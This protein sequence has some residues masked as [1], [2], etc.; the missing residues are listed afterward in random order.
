[1]KCPKC[2]K[3]L[4]RKGRFCRY[5]GTG[6]ETS[7]IKCQHINGADVDFCTRCGTRIGDLIY[8]ESCGASNFPD[9][10]NCIKCA[11][12][13][14]GEDSRSTNLPDSHDSHDS[15][16]SHPR[17]RSGIAAG[18]LAAAVFLGLLVTSYWYAP[19]N[20]NHPKPPIP[21]PVTVPITV[22]SPIPDPGP[23]VPMNPSDQTGKGSLALGSWGTLEWESCHGYYPAAVDSSAN[24]LLTLRSLRNRA[25]ANDDKKVA[26]DLILVLDCSGSMGGY[27]AN[28][29]LPYLREA[30]IKGTSALSSEDRITLII[31]SNEAETIINRQPLGDGSLLRNAVAGLEAQGGTNIGDA[32]TAAGAIA[33]QAPGSHIFIFT[34]GM[35]TVGLDS[36][37]GPGGDP[38]ILLNHA[39][40]VIPRNAIVSTMGLGTDF[41][42]KLMEQLARM[43]GGNYHYA[44][45]AGAMADRFREEV[46]GLSAGNCPSLTLE[47]I[48]FESSDVKPRVTQVLNVNSSI[49]GETTSLLFE[50]VAEG[51]A[52]SSLL[53]MNLVA[54]SAS[55]KGTVTGFQLIARWRDSMDREKTAAGQ[56]NMGLSH[57]PAICAASARQNIISL[58]QFHNLAE[59][60]RKALSALRRGSADEARNIAR[61]ARV[62]VKNF[63]SKL[64]RA[65]ENVIRQTR[66]LIEDLDNLDSS[67]DSGIS[68]SA[69]FGDTTGT[70]TTGPKT[71]KAEAGKAMESLIKKL[72]YRAYSADRD[73][74]N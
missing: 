58:V 7:C 73:I 69:N 45:G 34:D 65:P 52:R 44:P 51:G 41:N 39:E 59:E 72:H 17:S 14:N 11:N 46:M 2:S 23:T 67:A 10:E 27:R 36:G 74:M 70:G 16:E 26:R 19:L 22:I 71:K 63:S 31:Y 24:I 13:L 66:L 15:D 61:Q 30:I 57:D 12:Q 55:G 40:K 49:G 48:P 50:G 35:S 38:Q 54:G 62:Q 18:F 32:L 8:C 4:P 1:M 6:I 33:A 60:R 37:R 64:E 20:Q 68:G 25:A 56:I 43:R 9:S 21:V 29:A 28:P 3:P 47:L 5:C 42:E 53:S